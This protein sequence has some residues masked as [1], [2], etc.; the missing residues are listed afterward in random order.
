MVTVDLPAGLVLQPVHRLRVG[1]F[2]RADPPHQH[3]RADLLSL[4]HQGLARSI[5][6]VGYPD[7]HHVLRAAPPPC[8]SSSSARGATAAAL[9]G[10]DVAA[11]HSFVIIG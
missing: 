8:A 7:G 9:W 11:V 5:Q 4:D 3:H 6:D 2:R 10:Q 1:A